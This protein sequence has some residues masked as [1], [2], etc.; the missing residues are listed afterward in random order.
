MMKAGVQSRSLLQV[1]GR[2]AYTLKDDVNN[3][4]KKMLCQCLFDN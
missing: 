1:T 2:K 3:K 4:E